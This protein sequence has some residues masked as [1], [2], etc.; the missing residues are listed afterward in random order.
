MIRLFSFSILFI[1]LLYPQEKTAYIK[2]FHNNRDF[3]GDKGMLSS[4]RKGEEHIQVSYNEKKQAILKEWIDQYGQAKKREIFSYDN[5]GRLFSR[6]ILK[7]NEKPDKI[8]TYGSIEPW[9]LEF[10]KYLYDD[11]IKISFENQRSEF[12]MSSINQV[13][14]IEFYTIDNQFYGSI[15]FSYDR[16]G[17]V[18]NEIWVKEPENHIIRRFKYQYDIMAEVKKIWEYDQNGSLI[19]NQVLKQAPA[20]ELYKRPP[21]RTGNMLS[22]AGL[23]IEELRTKKKLDSSPAFIPVTV[24]D[25]LITNNDNRVDID[26]ISVDIHLLKF[27]E[28]NAN[29]ILSIPTDRIVSVVSRFGEI[30]YP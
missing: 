14:K 29:D 18:N 28:P 20:D 21:P 16:L 15:S 4:D 17:F 6:A 13:E 19:S 24:W 7:K 3:L 2:Y 11:N 25:Q 26:F 10:R 9:G 5:E 27:K 23:I 8:I 30:I 1:A 12:Q 22:E